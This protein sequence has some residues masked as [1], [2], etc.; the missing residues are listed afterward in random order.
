M[1]FLKILLITLLIVKIGW[2]IAIGA[3]L[4]LRHDIILHRNDLVK[5]VEII[6]DIL[7]LILT[8]CIGILLIYLFHH[9]RSDRVC[10]EGHEKMYLY[11]FGILCA[12]GSVK[13]IF[14]NFNHE[15]YMI[16]K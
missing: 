10:I 14:Y 9:L 16:S 3:L 1:N 13:K 8:F 15:I 2:I 4:L 11:T 5:P 7:H 6:E 12:I